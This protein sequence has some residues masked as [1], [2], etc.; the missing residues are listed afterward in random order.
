MA[1]P[2]QI[3]TVLHALEDSQPKHL[4]RTIDISQ[5]G[6]GAVLRQLTEATDTLTA[7]KIA[8]EMNVSTA[9][10]AVLLKKMAAKGLILKEADVCDARVTVVRLTPKGRE[11]AAS[12]RSH[13]CSHI[14]EVIDTVGMDRMLEYVEIS[15]QIQDTIQHFAPPEL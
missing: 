4:F 12:L 9:R 1:T 13:I 14:G 6:I 7:G 11:T 5:A 10:V 3:E 2:E 15:R 8:E